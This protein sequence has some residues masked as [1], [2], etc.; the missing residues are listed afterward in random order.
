[1]KIEREGRKDGDSERDREREKEAYATAAQHTPHSIT[2]PH[3]IQVEY[4]HYTMLHYTT[5]HHS[6]AQYIA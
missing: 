3:K 5:P 2:A 1:V 4:I 6:T